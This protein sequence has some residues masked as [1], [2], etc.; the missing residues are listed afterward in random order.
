MDKKSTEELADLIF[1]SPPEEV[2]VEEVASAVVVEAS[3]VVVAS[4]AAV[5]LAETEVAS[6]VAEVLEAVV[7][8]AV[9]EAVVVASVAAVVSVAVVVSVA[10]LP[11]LT[12]DSSSLPKT[13]VLNSELPINPTSTPLE[14]LT[15][16]PGPI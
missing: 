9:I 5:A 1:P 7:A 3:V 14:I 16:V 6:V 10:M 4:V 8:L 11:E 2:P 15:M 12:K 13:K